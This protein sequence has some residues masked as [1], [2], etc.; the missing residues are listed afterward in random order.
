MG[1][2]TP[3]QRR[4]TAQGSGLSSRSII[5]QHNVVHPCLFAQPF[6]TDIFLL[7]GLKQALNEFTHSRI[8]N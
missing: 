1:S 2:R 5:P 8:T 3:R 6:L 4:R 7:R